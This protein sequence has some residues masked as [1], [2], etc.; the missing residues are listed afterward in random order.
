MARTPLLNSLIRLARE[1]T[2]A[3]QNNLP[4]DAVRELAAA[5]IGRRNLLKGAAAAAVTAAA[6]GSGRALAAGGPKIAIVGGGIAGLVASLTLKDA[7]IQSTIYEAGGRIG[8]RMFSNTGYFN[9]GQVS[10]WGGELID[11]NHKLV[12][13]LA[14][15]YNL[16]L[17]DLIQAQPN[18]SE[19]TYMFNGVYYPKS[20][21]DIDFQPVHNALQ[22]D[23]QTA[24][25]PTT[26]NV[27]TPGGIALDNMSV[28]E[29]IESRVPGGHSSPLGKLLDIAYNIEYGAET[30]DQSALN[31]IYLLGYGA[32]PG[33]FTLFGKSDE[34]YHVR[35][36]NQQ[37]PA[38]IA[39]DLSGNIQTGY[40]LTKISRRS[41]GSVELIFDTGGRTTTTVTADYAI[42]ALPFAVLRTLD[43]AGCNFDALKNKAIQEQGAG[44][45]GKLNTQFSSRLWNTQ[46]PWGKSNGSAVADT[47]FQNTWEVTRAQPGTSGILVGYSGGNVSAAM[48]TTVPWTTVS[49]TQ[50][51]YD[52]KT[53]LA[54]LEP[55]FPG[56]TAKWNGKAT[57]SLPFL[58][59]NLKLAYSYWK[60]GQCH[61]IG[62]YE[63][64]SQGNILFAGEHTSVDYQGYMEGG[65]TEGQ[66]AA[67][68]LIALFK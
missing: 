38:A 50:A 11:T 57:S 10:E 21:A 23:V 35:G 33:N 63:R 42:L 61:T 59:P 58:D 56:I 68:E 47:G 54:R 5:Q 14:R 41:D 7:G 32:K 53:F 24:S 36:G 66:R 30:T 48:K 16:V 17:D 25:Y 22:G 8:G 28:Y 55:V 2:V 60:V 4:V 64:V 3:S 44:K 39:Q 19:D 52:T 9:E 1:H 45:N 26:Y 40:R 20:Q 65:A 31:L 12:Q 37:I 62:G 46:G 18:G 34:R 43:Y 27:N 67:N 51:D 13:T 6:L 29:W 15:R 49:N